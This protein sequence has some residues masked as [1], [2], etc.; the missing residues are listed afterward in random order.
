M[1]VIFYSDV[2]VQFNEGFVYDRIIRE[3]PGVVYDDVNEFDLYMVVSGNIFYFIG[4]IF[5]FQGKGWN[6]GA[7]LS[8]RRLYCYQA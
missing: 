4:V 6:A 7:K 8:E 1:S 2:I 5:E 3:F